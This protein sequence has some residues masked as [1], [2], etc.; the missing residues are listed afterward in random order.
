MNHDIPQLIQPVII[1]LHSQ[2]VF[3]LSHIAFKINHNA[4]KVLAILYFLTIYIILIT[5]ELNINICKILSNRFYSIFPKSINS[6]IQYIHWT[7]KF[8]LIVIFISLGTVSKV[9]KKCFIGKL[10]HYETSLE[11]VLKIDIGALI[12]QISLHLAVQS[13]VILVNCSITNSIFYHLLKK[14]LSRGCQ[15]TKPH[16]T[17]EYYW[18]IHLAI[19]KR[20]EN[21]II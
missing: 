7:S 6:V 16:Y 4:S 11:R 5:K 13:H 2:N 18:P 8:I 10:E 20:H 15:M 17:T 12:N 1:C 14:Y 3:S 19:H 21:G 9:V